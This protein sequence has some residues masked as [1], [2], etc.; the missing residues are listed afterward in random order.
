MRTT[1]FL[2][3]VFADA[4]VGAPSFRSMSVL[5]Q[6]SDIP[7]GFTKGSSAPATK[8]L[9]LRIALKQ[10]DMAGLE[11]ALYDVSTPGS[12]LYG[13]HLTKEEVNKHSLMITVVIW[14]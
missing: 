8:I 6:R 11:K 5:E 12:K 13:Q 3:A 4:I 1:I 10:N 2:L 9:N 7:I 14:T